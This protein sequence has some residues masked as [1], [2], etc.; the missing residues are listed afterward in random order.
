MLSISIYLKFLAKTILAIE[1]YSIQKKNTHKSKKC[2]LQWI[3]HWYDMNVQ[4]YG[5]CWRKERLATGWMPVVSFD[6][7]WPHVFLLIRQPGI[8]Q[9]QARKVENRTDFTF[10][11]GVEREWGTEHTFDLLSNILFQS[12]TLNCSIELLLLKTFSSL[13][14]YSELHCGI[15]WW[16][17]VRSTKFKD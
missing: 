15:L 13:F 7:S 11:Y 6:A 5:P 14:A 3:C 4:L 17:S 2:V 1:L 12:R 9:T 10:N 8:W 16:C